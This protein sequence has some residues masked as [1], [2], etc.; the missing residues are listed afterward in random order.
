[1]N[2]S[3]YGCVDV[4]NGRVLWQKIVEEAVAKD[5]VLNSPLYVVY[6]QDNTYNVHSAEKGHFLASFTKDTFHTV[7][8]PEFLLK[9]ERKKQFYDKDKEATLPLPIVNYSNRKVH[10]K[11][12]IENEH[13]GAKSDGNYPHPGIEFY[14]YWAQNVE[15]VL[16]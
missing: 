11:K 7:F 5:I 13:T 4:R 16:M 8:C 14:K 2:R 1:M 9:D 10:I 15:F 6:Y 12:K 3:I